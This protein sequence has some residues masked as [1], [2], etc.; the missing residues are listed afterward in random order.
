MSHTP[1]LPP[2]RVRMRDGADAVRDHREDEARPAYGSQ[3]AMIS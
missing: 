2:V 1:G 3:T